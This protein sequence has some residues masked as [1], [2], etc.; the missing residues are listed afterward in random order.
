MIWRHKIEECTGT[1]GRHRGFLATSHQRFEDSA[2]FRSGLINKIPRCPQAC[3]LLGFPQGLVNNA[4]SQ[5]YLAPKRIIRRHFR[6]PSLPGGK[7][8][9]SR[10]NDRLI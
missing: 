2:Q 8:P 4:K 1:L 9:S 7:L 6:F 10:G 5:Q 3:S